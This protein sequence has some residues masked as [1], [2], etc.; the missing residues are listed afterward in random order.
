MVVG[1]GVFGAAAALELRRRGY[2]VTLVDRGGPP[3]P[4]A[5]STDVSK[6]VRMDYGAD[7][8]YHELAEAALAGWDE[9]NRAEP[10]PLYHETG[11]LVLASEPMRAGS[12]EAESF[13]TLRDRGYEPDRL[14]AGALG[15]RFPAWNADRY[16]DGYVSRRGGWAESG[17]V[18]S[19]LVSRGEEEG[20]RPVEGTFAALREEGS[21]IAGVRLADG[22][23][24]RA[25]RVVVAAGAW[26]PVLLPW[27]RPLL[28]SVAQ[29]VVHLAPE[30]P[31]RLRPPGFL[32]FAADISGSGW[33]GFPALP[34]GQLK[35]G[36]H[37]M[38]KEAHPDERGGV[39][40]AHL[41][42]L[43]DFLSDALPALVDAP[44]AATR[45]CMYCDAVDG[46][47]LIG[48][49]PL[50]DGLVVAGGGSGHG[51]KFAPLLGPLVADALEG[52]ENRWS[53]RLGWRASGP[54]RTEAAR[55]TIPNNEPPRKEEAG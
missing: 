51:F 47:L 21:R 33:Y 1:A 40:G 4:E 3:H 14:D 44:V 24:L 20:V 46:D 15:S 2:E 13:R 31:E 36:H 41:E 48:R 37:G 7:V 43:R 5:S 23:E 17:A 53:N 19:R 38:G 18:V 50:R 42:R 30:A 6:V 26:T 28:R 22:R 8:F 11:F 29:P 54:V 49:D 52:R 45:T 12:F 55:H 16:P 32:P 27:L 10:R 39:G 9:W 34:D 25:D 35:I